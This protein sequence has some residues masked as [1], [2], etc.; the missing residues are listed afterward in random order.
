MQQAATLRSQFLCE[1]VFE[2]FAHIPEM[3]A[4]TE[5]KFTLMGACLFDRIDGKPK[6]RKIAVPQK[7]TTVKGDGTTVAPLICHAEAMGSVTILSDLDFTVTCRANVRDDAIAKAREAENDPRWEA[8]VISP[9]DE[10]VL[11]P[12][13]TLPVRLTHRYKIEGGIRSRTFK[14]RGPICKVISVAPVTASDTQTRS[15]QEQPKPSSPAKGANQ[16]KVTLECEPE[17]L[18]DDLFAAIE[19]DVVAARTLRQQ[20]SKGLTAPGKDKVGS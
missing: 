17:L 4:E 9:V 11:K 6:T 16:F 14:S 7:L 2:D 15:Q 10:Q 18:P 13:S 12:G 3:L 1:V 19:A 8:M 5:D 20:A